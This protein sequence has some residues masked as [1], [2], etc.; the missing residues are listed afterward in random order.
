MKETRM[1]S[2]MKQ[3]IYVRKISEKLTFLP[4]V[5]LSGGKNFSFSERNVNGFKQ[6][7]IYSR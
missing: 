6:K 7:Q 1:V 2:S 5:C 3:K 4:H